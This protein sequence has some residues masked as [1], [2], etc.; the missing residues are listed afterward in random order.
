MTTVTAATDIVISSPRQE[1]VFIMDDVGNHAQLAASFGAGREVVILDAAGDGLAQIAQALEGRSGIDA[2]HVISHGSAGGVALGSLVLGST[3]VIARQPELAAIGRSLA[4]DADVLLYG[5][6]AGAGGGLADALAIATGADV[7]MSDDLTGHTALGAD[8][9][10]EVTSGNI[11]TAPLVDAQLA[12]GW[13]DVLAIPGP[14][15]ISFD[16]YGRF[17]NRGSYYSSP[18]AVYNVNGDAGYQLVIDGALQGSVTYGYGLVYASRGGS[19]S[20]VTLSFAD[21]KVFTADS[22]T[23]WNVANYGGAPSTTQTFVVQGFAANG[24]QVGSAQTM[25]SSAMA[26]QT[27]NFSG[28]TDITTLKITATT[29]GGSLYFFAIDAL[30]I[31]DIGFAPSVTSVSSPTVAGTYKVGDT[32]QVDV[33]FDESVVVTGTPRMTLETGTTDRVIDYVSGS[34]STVL[35][36]SY[37]VQAGDRSLDLEVLSTAAL[38]LNGGTIQSLEGVDAVVSLPTPGASGSLSANEQLVID[39]VAPTAAITASDTTL[40]AGETATVTFTFTENPGASFT[41]ADLTVTGGTLGALSGAGL[42]RT[43]TF[44]PT[45]GTNDGTASITLGSNSYADA[46][47]NLGGSAGLTLSFDTLAPAA[48]SAPD[49][50]PVSDS[51]SSATDDITRVAT[52]AFTGTAEAGATVRLFDTDGTTVLGS[53]TADGSGNWSITSSTMSQGSHTVTVRAIDAAGNTSS[54]SSG[55]AVTIDTTAPAVAITSDRAALAAGETATITFSFTENPG[56]SFTLGD[57]AVSGGTLG[58]LS[59]AGITRTATFTPTAS[60]DGGVASITLS[61]GSWADAAGNGGG[62]G[63]RPALTFDTRAPDAPA[64]PEVQVGSDTGAS[65]SDGITSDTTPTLSGTAEAGATVRLYATDGTTVLRSTT[66]GIDGSWFLTAPALAEGTHALTVRAEDA[67]GNLGAASP[68][69]TVVIDTAAPVASSTPDLDAGSDTGRAGDDDITADQTPTVTG[70]AESGALVTLYDANDN[71]LGQGVATGGTWSI[72]SSTLGEGSHLLHTRVTDTAGNVGPASGALAVLVDLSAPMTTV[73]GAT[74]SDDT[75]RSGSDFV[76]SGT[77]QV[78][79]GTLSAPLQA[80]EAVQVSL[81]NGAT[82]DVATAGA[83]DATWSHGATL[84][85]SGTLHVRVT[86]ALDRAGVAWSQDYVLDTL[87]PGAPSSPELAARSDTGNS[88]TDRLTRD[89]TPTLTGTADAGAAVALY[90][91][92]GTTVLG[93]ATTDTSGDWSITSAALAAGT[94][95]LTALATDAAGNTSAAS[96]PLEITVDHRAPTVRTVASPQ[97][98][99]E[100]GLGDVIV[101]SVRFSET[102]LVD[103]APQLALETGSVDRMATFAGGSGTQMLTFRYTVQAGDVSADLDYLGTAAIHLAGGSI[104][105]AAGNAAT[106]TLPAP[107]GPGSLADREDIAVDGVA[108]TLVAARID[109]KVLVLRYDETLDGSKLPAASAF[110][111]QAGGRDVDIGSVTFNAT[112]NTLVLR[113]DQAVAQGQ[114]VSVDYRDAAWDQARAIQD[115]LGNDAASLEDVTVRN[116]TLDRVAAAPVQMIGVADASEGAW[117]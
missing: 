85:G 78:I 44:T 25:T 27:L 76:T 84:T 75:G 99:G 107:G 6:E 43:A 17:S 105:D 29:N 26:T 81:D 117:L 68:A 89:R 88:P 116:I 100:Y 40:K 3:E 101:I 52:P 93:T 77:A 104:R 15:S 102:V 60:T 22:V 31:S 66:A 69:L 39:G 62:A 95:Q 24:S 114:A 98:A 20:A 55:L 64:V 7:A 51:G 110:T 108:P 47:G 67:A 109:G 53:T 46:A 42:V 21:G 4:P 34:G 113:L 48:P 36:F 41:A 23:L 37:T 61:A 71:V 63:T 57:V 82:W 91:T 79:S 12:A 49:M 9:D 92:D 10:L 65:S 1:I 103:G 13:Q 11:E 74:L 56:A 59:G 5:C 54:A 72:T 111:V 86:D 70:T 96:G 16:N 58:A 2:L 33:A 32:I 90:D 83:G 30:A 80:G 94:H 38:S 50:N 106:L 18:N 45:A 87:A 28:L 97:E 112:N 8:W 115:L 14:T 73:T 19:E 35:T